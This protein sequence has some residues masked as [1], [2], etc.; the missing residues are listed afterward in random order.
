MRP[1]A[2]SLLLFSSSLLGQSF[3]EQITFRPVKSWAIP[4]E[5]P[6]TLILKDT[7]GEDV[8]PRSAP[9]ILRSAS[10][11]SSF[12]STFYAP[13]RAARFGDP[14]A[15]I[16]PPVGQQIPFLPS[17]G[18]QFADWDRQVEI[19]G[20]DIT[21]R[22]TLLNLARAAWDAYHP[23]PGDKGWYD[24]HGVNWVCVCRA[25]RR[26]LFPFRPALLK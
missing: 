14:T 19:A 6:S 13:S 24:I 23:M 10:T 22:E 17:A 12:P 9:L 8:G 2:L 7:P 26:H 16:N 20:P 1:R 25:W 5:A 15:L 11:N 18:E 21:D 4:D 3:G